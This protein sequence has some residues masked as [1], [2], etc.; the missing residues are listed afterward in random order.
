MEKVLFNLKNAIESCINEEFTEFLQNVPVSK[1]GYRTI[2]PKSP[3]G[4][5]E[6]NLP[7]SRW[8]KSEWNIFYSEIQAQTVTDML[9]DVFHQ[10]LQLMKIWNTF[11][12]IKEYFSSVYS[13]PISNDFLSKV[14]NSVYDE[15][16]NWKSHTLK[17]MYMI[18][19]LDAMYIKLKV[20]NPNTWRYTIQSVPV[21]FIIWIDMEWEKE[22]LDF[23]ITQNQE[24][25]IFWQE[26]INNLSN[27]GIQDILFACVDWLPWLKEWILSIF[28]DTIVQPC[29]VHK[30]RNIEKYVNYKDRKDFLGDIH[31]VYNAVNQSQAEMMLFKMQEKWKKYK[32][33]LDDWLY[34][35]DY[36][37]SYFK[38]SYRIRRLIYTTNIIE[39]WNSLVR[40]TIGRRKVYFTQKSAEISIFL[41]IM[42]REKRLKNVRWIKELQLELMNFFPERMKI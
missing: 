36:W 34:D 4:R 42:H 16:M 41:A 2:H 31:R 7:R 25:W 33:L 12:D 14:Y 24:S 35:I 23:V 39:N 29:I 38:F 30:V 6:I 40:T 1:N 32:R 10:I 18:V 8:K 26:I 27:R 9:D 22:I 3:V 17:S 21:Y 37:G 5:V 19:Y 13:M 11:D 15:I 20:H 28:P